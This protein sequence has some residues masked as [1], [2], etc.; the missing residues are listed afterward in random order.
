[1]DDSNNRFYAGR[2]LRLV[3]IGQISVRQ[4]VLEYPKDTKDESLIAAY[5]ALIHYEADEEIN[6]ETLNSH[7]LD[8]CQIND[9]L[10][11][12][13]LSYTVDTLYGAEEYVGSDTNWTF[14]DMKKKWE[15]MPENA[16]FS[17][18]MGTNSIDSVYYTLIGVNLS[19]FINYN[20]LTCN[21]NS[22]EF[23]DVLDFVCQFDKPLYYK[24]DYESDI[25][26]VYEASLCGFIQFHNT[27]WSPNNVKYTFV[28]YPSYEGSKSLVEIMDAFAINS[29]SA[30]EVQKGAWEFLKFLSSIDY[31]YE[32]MKPGKVVNYSGE[33]IEYSEEICFPINN[34]AF[35]K[36]AE[37]AFEMD[38]HVT[39]RQVEQDRGHFTQE[40]YEQLKSIINNTNQLAYFSDSSMEKL[41]NDSLVDIGNREKTSEEIAELFQNKIFIMINE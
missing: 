26:F 6:R 28:G 36:R 24:A 23:I 15:Q 11:F 21:F 7:V 31:Q 39:V 4:A 8:L 16:Y 2:L 9:D 37:E 3:R 32:M 20:D 25:R 29:N 19:S 10:Y 30:P 14:E 12:L 17:G 34:E 40:E 35:D 13:P 27:N 38:G 41:I 1:M 33:E 22:K 5:H 18:T